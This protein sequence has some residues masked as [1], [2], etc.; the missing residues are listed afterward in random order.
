MTATILRVI[1]GIMTLVSLGVVGVRLYFMS[2]Q[3]AGG[4]MA[5]LGLMFPLSLAMFFG[6]LAWKGKLPFDHGSDNS[7][8][9]KN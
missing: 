4:I 3:G 1:A 6:Y 2:T 9:P 8:G 5:S 7:A